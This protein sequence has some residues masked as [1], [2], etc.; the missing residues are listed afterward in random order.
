MTFTV[1]RIFRTLQGEGYHAGRAAVFCRFAGCNLWSGHEKD[2]ASA[3]CKFCDTVFVGGDKYATARDLADAIAAAWGDDVRNRMVVFTGGEPG[4]QLTPELIDEMHS[5]LFATHVE[6]NGTRDL[7]GNVRWITLSPKAGAE[8]RLWEANELKVA[9]PQ[10]ID[11]EGLRDR[12]GANFCYLQPI[13]G[14]D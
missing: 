13:A 4:L 9:W 3:V 10:K 7:P 12:I 5:R 11:L 2:R 6:T 14:P 1:H 8:L